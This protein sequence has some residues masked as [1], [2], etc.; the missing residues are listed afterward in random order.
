MFIQELFFYLYPKQKF[1]SL[2]I[3]IP[4]YLGVTLGRAL[5]YKIKTAEKM[6]TRNNINKK[7]ASSEWKEDSNTPRIL[8]VA[9]TQSVADYC[10]LVWP[11][12]NFA[13]R[14]N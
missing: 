12:L 6:I 8:I 9:L 5:T 4:K 13:M 10:T 7:L 11:Q 2:Q 3:Q 1:I 14:I